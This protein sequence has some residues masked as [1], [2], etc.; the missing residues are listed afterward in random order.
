MKR[1]KDPI[2]YDVTVRFYGF[3]AYAARKL[4]ETGLYGKTEEE[5][6]RTLVSEGISKEISGLL[7]NLGITLEDA[8]KENYI[9]IKLDSESKED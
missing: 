2:E 7:K 4:V 6:V 1:K 8:E 5:V 3:P 9:P